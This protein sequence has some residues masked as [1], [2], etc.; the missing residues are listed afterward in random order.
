[1]DP[2]VVLTVRT[3]WKALEGAR[4]GTSDSVEVQRFLGLIPHTLSRIE[5][6]MKSPSLKPHEK[7]ICLTSYGQILSIQR[8]FKVCDKRGGELH[9][10]AVT[11][12]DGEKNATSDAER[13]T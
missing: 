9:Q 6:L 5:T 1:M 11:A 7:R 3:M 10:P 2:Y 12:D 4:N 13:V 8:M